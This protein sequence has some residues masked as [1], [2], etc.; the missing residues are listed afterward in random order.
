MSRA[1]ST[2]LDVAVALLLVSAAVGVVVAQDRARHTTP[3]A[4]PA[5]EALATS[6]TT[7]PYTL[8]PDGRGDQ[9]VRRT[10]HGTLLDLAA[11][12]AV[13]NVSVRASQV[14][15]AAD[16]YEAVVRQAI[17]NATGRRTTVLATWAP[18][19]GSPVAGTLRAGERPPPAATT[20]AVAVTVDSGCRPVA[21]GAVA[22]AADG[23]DAVARVVARGVIRCQFPARRT[24]LALAGDGPMAAL[25]ARRY[26]RMATLTGAD[27]GDVDPAGV[28]RA[29][30]LLWRALAEGLESDMRARFDSPTAAARAVDVG[31]VEVV[32]RRW[33]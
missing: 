2:V 25:V 29:N 17:V 31:T 1:V 18:Y 15:H 20:A 4:S 9:S 13:R 22:A 12:A 19:P 28:R 30:T 33:T 11:D 24:R 32:V 7:V 8:D 23:F 3:D 14:S 5:A 21:D 6:T 16:G 27:T 10:A 26:D